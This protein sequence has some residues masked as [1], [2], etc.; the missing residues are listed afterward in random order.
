M[1][2]LGSHSVLA[3]SGDFFQ[4]ALKDDPRQDWSDPVYPEQPRS[5]CACQD[6]EKN[7]GLLRGNYY[8]GGNLLN[9]LEAGE[10]CGATC[11]LVDALEKSDIPE[12]QKLGKAIDAGKTEK[13][14]NEKIHPSQLEVACFEDG[15]YQNLVEDAVEETGG[16]FRKFLERIE[17][18][19]FSKLSNCVKLVKTIVK[20]SAA[21]DIKKVQPCLEAISEFP[22][23]RWVFAVSKEFDVQQILAKVSR[24]VV[25]HADV[26]KKVGGDILTLLDYVALFRSSF[27]SVFKDRR[28]I[29]D[30]H[31]ADEDKEKGDK[32]R[33][34]CLHEVESTSQC[35][36]RGA[37][38]KIAAVPE[39]F[40]KFISSVAQKLLCTGTAFAV[41]ICNS[42]A[43]F[44]QK[45]LVAFVKETEFMV[46]FQSFIFDYKKKSDDIDSRRARAVKN[47]KMGKTVIELAK[48]ANTFMT[49]KFPEFWKFVKNAVGPL[50]SLGDAVEARGE[51]REM[52]RK[53]EEAEESESACFEREKKEILQEC[54]WN[55]A[56]GCKEEDTFDSMQS[57]RQ[58]WVPTVRGV[59]QPPIPVAYYAP[60]K[61]EAYTKE[62]CKQKVKKREEREESDKKTSDANA[63][64]N[65]RENESLEDCEKR[66][67]EGFTKLCKEKPD[68]SH[69]Q[70]KKKQEHLNTQMKLCKERDEEKKERTTE[71]QEATD[72]T[73]L[74]RQIAMESAEECGKRLQNEILEKCKKQKICK[75]DDTFDSMQ[76][77]LQKWFPTVRGVRQPPIPVAYQPSDKWNSRKQEKCEKQVKERK[78]FETRKEE[79]DAQMAEVYDNTQDE[80]HRDMFESCQDNSIW[81]NYHPKDVKDRKKIDEMK[82]LLE[83]AKQL[84]A[85]WKREFKK[86]QDF[87]YTPGD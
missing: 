85:E 1:L 86:F 8:Y 22:H 18:L 17:N 68:S 60:D 71:D 67:M 49:Q 58:K 2:Y 13:E 19:E 32:K 39:A 26:L 9:L 83:D 59:R 20:D 56:F 84:C 47:T 55:D 70:E 81:L 33:Q 44:A 64:R 73:T 21:S 50:T 79:L 11:K 7:Q 66:I 6:K 72:A 27:K 78:K 52:A 48:E 29:C 16:G 46:R 41:I 57:D 14:K 80:Y 43:D 5:T 37:V 65:K 36:A 63:A 82:Q 31:W 40:I 10:N 87:S 35:V 28:C 62:N 23:M 54:K 24:K 76:S 69:C 4:D 75:D 77:D 61:W 34:K 3:M 53:K 45:G 30:M 25:E 42:V 12:C 15:T 74:E 38:D 51:A